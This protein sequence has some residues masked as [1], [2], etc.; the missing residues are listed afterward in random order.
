MAC[1]YKTA[2]TKTGD[3]VIILK[4]S[5]FESLDRIKL[6][7][8]NWRFVP[9]IT[10]KIGVRTGS[11]MQILKTLEKVKSDVASAIV[12]ADPPYPAVA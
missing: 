7:Q 10:S 6:S 12:L 5:I 2:T 11:K 8:M 1:H 3:I 9:L 4:I